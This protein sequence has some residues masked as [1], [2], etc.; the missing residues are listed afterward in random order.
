MSSLSKSVGAATVRASSTQ[1]GTAG[2][3]GAP[4]GGDF[5]S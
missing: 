5:S 4:N 2:L 3:G 1:S